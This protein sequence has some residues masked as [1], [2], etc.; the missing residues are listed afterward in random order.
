MPDCSGTERCRVG[1]TTES[2][3]MHCALIHDAEVL[4]RPR[5]Q[6]TATTEQALLVDGN[7]FVP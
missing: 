1:T 6:S 7:A 2:I 3:A 5:L 4:K